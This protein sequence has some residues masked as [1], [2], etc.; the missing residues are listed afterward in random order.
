METVI[1]PVI[2]GIIG[3]FGT[4]AG[5]YLSNK[6]ISKDMQRKCAIELETTVINQRVEIIKKATNIFG[7]VPGILELWLHYLEMNKDKERELPLEIIEKLAAYRGE[8]ESVMYMASL[9]FGPKTKLAI[10]EL[11]DEEVPWWSKSKEKQDAFKVAMV[12]EL[13]F[14]I[15]YIPEFFRLIQ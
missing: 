9:Y 1:I 3:V 11:S 15:K 2:T 13:G 12:Q 7:K 5:V 4:L 6:L 10:Q 14:A 8:F